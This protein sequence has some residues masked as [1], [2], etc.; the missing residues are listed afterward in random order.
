MQRVDS[1]EKTLM[2]GGIEGRRRRG[3]QRMRWL[4]GIN[5]SMDLSLGELQ[6]FVIEREAWP[7]EIHWLTKSWTQLS[8]WTELNWSLLCVKWM[9]SKILKK[10]KA[11]TIQSKCCLLETYESLQIILTKRHECCCLECLQT[12]DIRKCLSVF[13]PWP[14]TIHL[15][16]LSVV[17][18]LSLC[19]CVFSSLLTVSASWFWSRPRPH[20]DTLFR[21]F[22]KMAPLNLAAALDSPALSLSLCRFI[23]WS[24]LHFGVYYL[25]LGTLFT[26]LALPANFCQ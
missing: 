23:H 21:D 14:W 4:D 26:S 6:E 1:L 25:N 11:P 18:Q 2:V 9:N 12:H 5:D 24:S 15:A 22:F 3:P 13:P 8:D 16:L 10:K 17:G 20:I 19:S 7:A